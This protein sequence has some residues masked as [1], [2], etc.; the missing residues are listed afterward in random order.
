M[1][2]AFA[3][4]T[5]TD[6]EIARVNAEAPHEMWDQRLQSVELTARKLETL[7]RT[8]PSLLDSVCATSTAARRFSVRIPVVFEC[9]Y[10]GH[11][12]STVTG[13]STR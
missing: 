4:V 11:V 10:T 7:T 1:L 5:D 2:A 8:N 12:H 9:S 3:E 13:F 6:K